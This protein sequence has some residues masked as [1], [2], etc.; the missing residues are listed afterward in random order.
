MRPRFIG[1]IA[2]AV[3]GAVVVFV[4]S[5]GF[6]PSVR[7]WLTFGVS[8]GALALLA[9]AQRDG[10]RGRGQRIAHELKTE[11]VVHVF[12]AIFDEARNDLWGETR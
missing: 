3:A 12:E 1:N 5:Q 7:G 8:L 10:T 6:T 9:V 4:G 2:L 11:R